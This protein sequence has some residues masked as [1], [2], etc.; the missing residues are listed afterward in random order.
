MMFLAMTDGIRLSGFASLRG[1]IIKRTLY[2]RNI[3]PRG[4]PKKGLVQWSQ[5]CISL[6]IL[7]NCH[8]IYHLKLDDNI[9]YDGEVRPKY[10]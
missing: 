10:Q 6:K 1:G 2:K 5:L 7:K 9:I 3:Y 8:K 4:N